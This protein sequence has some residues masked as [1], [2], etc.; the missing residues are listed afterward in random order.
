MELETAEGAVCRPS[1]VDIPEKSVT[2]E[3]EDNSLNKTPKSALPFLKEN[4]FLRVKSP[5]PR[6]LSP[7]RLHTP[8]LQRTRSGREKTESAMDISKVF[9]MNRIAKTLVVNHK[10]RLQRLEEAGNVTRN[11]PL[12]KFDP[13]SVKPHLFKVLQDNLRHVQYDP[14]VCCHLSQLLSEETRNVVKALKFPRYKFVSLVTIGQSQQST[15]S[16]SSRSVWDCDMDNHVC[17]EY[18][19]Q[20]LY[21]VA[22]IFATFMD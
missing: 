22:L 18:R 1:T 11:A 21:A 3:S 10:T 5:S 2:N 12:K 7:E 19:N 15:V 9:N 8:F 20:T 6:M 14:E 17:A 16:I 4:P 13:D